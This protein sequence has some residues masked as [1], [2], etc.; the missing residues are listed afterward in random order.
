L[1]DRPRSNRCCATSTAR[2]AMPTL[3]SALKPLR[4]VGQQI[5][6]RFHSA[7]GSAASV[8]VVP[9]G[10][11]P[12]TDAIDQQPTPDA[13]DGTVAFDTD[14]WDAGSYEAVLLD[15]GDA[16]VSR[17]PF[18]I[19]PVD[20]GVELSTGQP[21][22]AVGQPIDVSWTFAPARRWDWVGIYK[23]GRDPR[24][25]YYLVWSYTG[26]TVEGSTELGDDDHGPWP[27]PAGRYTIYLLTDD[28][29]RAL[30]RADFEVTG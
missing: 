25:A 11:D 21:T 9:A 30:A 10:G 17:I 5:H 29:Y 26:A 6:L 12:A 28:G 13:T 14:G 22:Y 23:R 2:S 27:L 7:D 4:E 1:F 8:A 24:V 19:R 3:V 18:W 15:G 16:E 20:G